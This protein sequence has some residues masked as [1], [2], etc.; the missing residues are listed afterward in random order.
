MRAGSRRGMEIEEFRRDLLEWF[1]VQQRDLPWRRTRDPYAILVSEVMLQQTRVE[2]VI[3]YYNE[4]LRRF[5]TVR[6]LAASAETDVLHAWQG[7]GYYA[8]ARSLHAAA[9]LI[10]HGHRG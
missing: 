3:P 9:K 2:T 10:T 5:P 8:R 6:R 1:T 4:W 7:L